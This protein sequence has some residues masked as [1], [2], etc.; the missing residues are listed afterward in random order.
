MNSLRISLPSGCVKDNTHLLSKLG[1]FDIYKPYFDPDIYVYLI[2]IYSLYLRLIQQIF[3]E[4]VEVEKNHLVSFFISS[5][6]NRCS[7]T[8]K[9]ELIE[10]NYFLLSQYVFISKTSPIGNSAMELMERRKPSWALR[11]LVKL[12]SLNVDSK[13]ILTSRSLMRVLLICNCGACYFV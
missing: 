4:S 9:K 13:G 3:N 6:C 5:S 11:R 1:V 10:Y 8:C 7:Y 12:H 2:L